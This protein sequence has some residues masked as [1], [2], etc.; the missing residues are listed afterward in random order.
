VIRAPEL[1]ASAQDWERL[2]E[3]QRFDDDA[4]ED[5]ARPEWAR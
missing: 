5:D 2:A 1:I 3:G 4:V